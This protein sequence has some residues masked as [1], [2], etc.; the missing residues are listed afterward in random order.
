MRCQV[1]EENM[2]GTRCCVSATGALNTDAEHRVP[3]KLGL[4]VQRDF[5]PASLL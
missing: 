1:A 2:V 5:F 4:C 3:T